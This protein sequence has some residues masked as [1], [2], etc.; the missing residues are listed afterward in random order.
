[1]W[2][3]PPITLNFDVYLY[4]WT[5]PTNLT[6]DDY[7]K[8]IVEQIGPYRFTEITDKSQIRWHPKNSTISYNRRSVYFF[9]AEESVG[10]LEDKI[11]TINAVAMVR[12][13]IENL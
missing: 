1:M 4:N 10:R 2:K 8:P 5:N 12:T 13:L 7:E 3:K 6:E 9:N 11:T